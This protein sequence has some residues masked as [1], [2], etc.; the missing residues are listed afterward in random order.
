MA[1]DKSLHRDTHWN[2]RAGTILAHWLH[3][4]LADPNNH[5][6]QHL[7]ISYTNKA[8]LEEMPCGSA[9]PY[10][11]IIDMLLPSITPSYMQS[12][13]NT[14][15][16]PSHLV[17][18]FLAMQGTLMCEGREFSVLLGPAKWSQEANTAAMQL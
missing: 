14:S 11:G 4:P 15:P 3:I 16:P 2:H 6:N 10:Q 12:V 17:F 5:H 13:Q 1:V 18:L 7:V 9:T 8:M